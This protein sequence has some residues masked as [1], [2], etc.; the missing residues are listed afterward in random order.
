MVFASAKGASVMKSTLGIWVSV[1]MLTAAGF[2]QQTQPRLHA[3]KAHAKPAV[4]TVAPVPG[5]A[6]APHSPL[7]N[8]AKSG[9]V[10]DQLN[11]LER[12]TAKTVAAKSASQNKPAVAALAPKSND[13]AAPHKA[14]N[15]RYQEPSGGVKSN[16]PQQSSTGRKSGLRRRVDSGR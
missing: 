7:A 8:N 2:A 12:D 16:Q 15:F 10:N 11:R 1:G 3:H 4:S 6:P 5:H 14:A 9:K 13:A